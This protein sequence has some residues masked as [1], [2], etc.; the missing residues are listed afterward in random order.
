VFRRTTI[1]SAS[2][3]VLLTMAG[4]VLT[5]G[6]AQASAAPCP[7]TAAEVAYG[8]ETIAHALRTLDHG[9]RLLGQG[10]RGTTLTPVENP[11]SAWNCLLALN[12]LKNKIRA[13]EW[14]IAQWVLCVDVEG[15][16]L[17][18]KAESSHMV[19]ALHDVDVALGNLAQACP[20][21][22]PDF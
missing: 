15:T 4:S 14:A 9:G 12:D 7:L 19:A 3:A 21:L 10:P 2:V 1:L 11:S 16:T 8:H 18:C 6:P 22:F 17:A 5:A 13:A 20:W